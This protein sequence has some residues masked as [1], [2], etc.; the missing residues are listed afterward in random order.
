MSRPI[1]CCTQRVSF[2]GFASDSLLHSEG[3][4]HMYHLFWWTRHQSVA[5]DS[6]FMR[7]SFSGLSRLIIY[8]VFWSVASD[9]LYYHLFWWTRHQS[10]ASD[11]LLH[12][13]KSF[14]GSRV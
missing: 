7:K 11:S 5:S 10:V 2:S 9:S 3:M 8:I 12:S 4:E 13:E 1:V 6:L 14:S